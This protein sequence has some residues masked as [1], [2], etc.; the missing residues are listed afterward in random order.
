MTNITENRI[1]RLECADISKGIGILLVI[2]GHC[3]YIGGSIH[4]WIF[5]FHMPLFFILSGMFIKDEPVQKFVGKKAR[6]LL[7]PYVVFCIIGLIITAV[8]PR[9]RIMLNLKN[10]L[11]DIYLAGPD[12][13][14]VSSVWFLVTL[15]LSSLMLQLC[16]KLKKFALIGIIVLCSV[17]FYIGLN[18]QLTDSLPAGRLPLSID[19]AMTALFF[20]SIGYYEKNLIIKF[21]NLIKKSFWLQCGLCIILFA[22]S[23]LA[24]YFNGR[25]NIH[26]PV[27]NNLL[28]YI[29]GAFVGTAFVIILSVSISCVKVLQ[30]IFIFIGR[31]S[32]I[33]LGVQAIMIRLYILAAECITGEEYKL[34][35]LPQVH[36]LISAVTV[37]FFSIAV[38]IAYNYLS[39]NIKEKMSDNRKYTE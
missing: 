5:S 35:Y 32:L 38:V 1:M 33:I 17:G 28:I 29:P 20:L 22:L 2:I 9:W 30:K 25:V 24:A 34:Y 39:K 3:V 6:T 10:I 26:E 19:V 7:I 14:N 36:A 18:G 4:N 8:I 12:H 11:A 37:T 27:F 31:N 13:I 15:F 16:L 21:T 23:V